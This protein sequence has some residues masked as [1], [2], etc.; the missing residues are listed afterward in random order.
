MKIEEQIVLVTGAGRGLG[1]ALARGFAREGPAWWS[2]I[3]VARRP[4]AS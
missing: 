3:A 4:P 1:A 2:T